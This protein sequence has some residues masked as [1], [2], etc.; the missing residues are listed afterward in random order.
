MM[1]TANATKEAIQD[2]EDAGFDAYLT[3]PVEP[4]KLLD[5]IA[6]L[7][8]NKSRNNIDADELPL[9][10]VSVNNP[11]KT[12]LLDIET[13]SAISSVAKSQDFMVK[14]VDGYVAN[15]QNLIEQISAAIAHKKHGNISDL[16]HSLHGSSR[17]IGANR[18][19]IIAEKLSRLTKTENRFMA[20]T[21]INELTLT[22]TQTK[23]ALYEFL[24]G[25]NTASL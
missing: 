17:S 24:Q 14:L 5:T 3:K 1:L 16:A 25:K 18:L 20:H 2:C 23:S 4:Q 11:Q 13:L 9:K 12:P 19:A 10:V 7:V 8:A 22:F 15:A 21:H 6:R